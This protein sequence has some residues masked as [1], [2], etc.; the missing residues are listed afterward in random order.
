MHQLTR[1]IRDNFSAAGSDLIYFDPIDWNPQPKFLNSIKDVKLKKFGVELNSK[2]KSLMR[3]FDRSTLCIGCVSTA[4]D[5][6]FPFI[7][8]G[9]RFRE[10]Y[11]WDTFWIIEGL[12]ASE[13]YDSAK[14]MIKNFLRMVELFGFVPNGSRLYYLN[15]S[16]PPLLVLM[17]N[18]YFEKTKDLVFLIEALPYLDQ[19]YRFWMRERSVKIVAKSDNLEY[20]LNLYT[21]VSDSPRPESYSEDLFDASSFPSEDEKI[22]FYSDIVAGAESGW[23]F[24]SRWFSDP[25]KLT[26]I[27]TSKIVPV[28]L[29]A[30][31]YKTEK[32][33][34]NFHRLTGN[35]AME[36]Q[37]SEAVEKRIR[38]INTILWDSKDLVWRDFS[39]ISQ[40]F[41][42]N[43][44]YIS[45]LFP[46]FF[47]I[48]P[49]GTSDAELLA[50]HSPYL[51]KYSAGI[52]VSEIRNGQQWDFPNVWAPYHHTVV[53]YLKDFD[54]TLALEIAQKFVNS[55]HRGWV[56]TG[57][58]FEKY[59]AEKVGVPG[60]GGEYVV[61]EGFGWTNGVV[62][63]FL[64]W[65]GDELVIIDN[66]NVMIDD[67]ALSTIIIF[68]T[69]L[70]AGILLMW[71]ISQKNEKYEKFE[72]L[73]TQ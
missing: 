45:S 29:N 27:Y 14:G 39:L 59:N 19:E 8:P 13:M 42:S 47:G 7:I 66:S 34:A 10:S 48:I 16:Q 36:S 67:V 44:F 52:P 63:S 5:L 65:F 21:P 49:A 56:N 15:R 20:L 35:A 61:Q 70:M 18:S 6:E 33:L 51:L 3:K 24:S 54:R 32:L 38:A 50:V 73:F 28:D 60:G 12:L 71:K 43:S 23:D 64:E 62:I 25:Q 11:Y 1:F 57:H 46:L 31:M 2:W 26:T 72:L 4:F 37:Y 22:R 68:L 41:T 69:L 55:V 17:V 30:F 58:I 40:E 53:S 9:G